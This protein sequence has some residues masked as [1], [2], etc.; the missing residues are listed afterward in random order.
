MISMK[1]NSIEHDKN[2]SLSVK[3]ENPLH[4]MD[5]HPLS[6]NDGLLEDFKHG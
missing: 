1:L 3:V 6:L 2:N 4:A 5:N